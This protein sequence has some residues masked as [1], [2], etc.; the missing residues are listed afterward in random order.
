MRKIRFQYEH[1][2]QSVEFSLNHFVCKCS[3]IPFLISDD[4]YG[5]RHS[6]LLHMFGGF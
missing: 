6:L 5:L 2:T 3:F 1:V 4:D